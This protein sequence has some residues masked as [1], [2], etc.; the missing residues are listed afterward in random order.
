MS[1]I[2][3]AQEVVLATND[4]ES[5]FNQFSTIEVFETGQKVDLQLGG[6]ALSRFMILS[7]AES[8]LH[9][10]A[11]NIFRFSMRYFEKVASSDSGPSVKAGSDIVDRSDSGTIL[12]K[13]VAATT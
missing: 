8:P 12:I 10:E 7:M 6:K 3:P 5:L 1:F 11:K 13:Y 2:F 4:V 9:I